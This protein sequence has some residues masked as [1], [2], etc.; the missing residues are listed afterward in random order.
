LN[1]P[2]SPT[3]RARVCL[4]QGE[5][6]RVLLNG[7]E[8]GALMSGALL[9][10]GLVPIVGDWVS[11]RQVEPD[12][13]LIEDVEP[14][15]SSITRRAPGRDAAE[16]VLAANVDLALIVCGL[17]GDFNVRRI[18]RYLAMA[19]DGNVEPVVILN[20]ADS[21][22]A[23]EKALLQAETV[24]RTTRVLAVSARTGFGFDAL[25][26]LLPAGVTVVLLGSSGAGKSSIVNRLFGGDRQRTGAVHETDS[27]GRHNTT[28]R[29]LIVLPNGAAIIDSPGIREL[30]LVVSQDALNLVFD[31]IVKLALAC[32]FRDCTHSIEPGCAVRHAVP[33]DRLESFGKLGREI[34]GIVEH[35]ATKRFHKKRG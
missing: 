13:V 22:D 2:E 7:Q 11:V 35:K 17:D 31:E 18:E 26:A 6:A 1:N 20:K 14:R 33:T 5:R 8:F 25:E 29:Q 3:L 12:W 4:S 23:V 10:K 9:A 27:R 16:Q 24:A 32:R 15:R 21:C 34:A 19:H 28:N 30:Q